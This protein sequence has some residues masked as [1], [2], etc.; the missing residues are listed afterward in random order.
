MDSPQYNSVLENM[1]AIIKSLEAT[2]TTSDLATQFQMNKWAGITANPTAKE[3]VVY[4]LVRIKES[5]AEFAILMEMMER[6][7]GLDQVVT[8]LRQTRKSV[9]VHCK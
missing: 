9:H 4:A 3:L 2:K 5:E 8:K 1:D 6:I 7:T